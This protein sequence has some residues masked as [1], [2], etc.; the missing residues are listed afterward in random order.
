MSNPSPCGRVH[1]VFCISNYLNFSLAIFIHNSWMPW[2][3]GKSNSPSQNQSYRPWGERTVNSSSYFP[4]LKF[5]E[6][7]RMFTYG[8][9]QSSP[10]G[11]PCI[12]SAVPSWGFSACL[13]FPDWQ[14]A[15]GLELDHP[16]CFLVA[17]NCLGRLSWTC[18]HWIN[19]S[20]ALAS[21][22]ACVSG[23]RPKPSSGWY[24]E[25]PLPLQMTCSPFC[26][27]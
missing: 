10:S 1:I 3:L 6:S 22:T 18:A 15:V 21:H 27:R 13:L 19:G 4:T 20:P 2:I 12:R 26:C 23:R 11:S 17:R 9:V 14:E 8:Q 24:L 25:K 5:G 7:C 16:S